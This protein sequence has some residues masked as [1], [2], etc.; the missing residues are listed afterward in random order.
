MLS[1]RERKMMK[2]KEILLS[3]YLASMEMLKTAISLCPDP[4]WCD[5][6]RRNQTWQ[7]AYHALFYTHLYLQPTE[8]DFTPWEKHHDE[9]QFMG[10]LPWPPHDPPKIG[11]PYTQAEVL[12]YL[13]FC[14]EQVKT[15][16]P[17]LGLEREDSGFSWLPFSKLELQFY[18]IRHLQLHTGEICERLGT[19][20]G[21]DVDWI[22]M[23]QP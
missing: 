1:F 3:Q 20:A 11:E 4:L 19:E 23:V 13:A 5:K 14:Q 7:V 2:I 18:N 9:Y 10:A 17:H 16:L 22:G 21:I 15:V 8:A 12:A 6:K